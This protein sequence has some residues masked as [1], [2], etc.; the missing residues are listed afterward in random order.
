VRAVAPPTLSP[1][2]WAIA[3]TGDLQL[4]DLVRVAPATLA[5]LARHGVD[6]R[7]GA[8]SL[9]DAARREGVALDAL[10]AE[11]RAAAAEDEER[12]DAYRA[13]GVI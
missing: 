8:R 10:L 12:V 5:V 1:A 7:A 13:A 11:L 6:P 4:G 2:G 3:I 9:A